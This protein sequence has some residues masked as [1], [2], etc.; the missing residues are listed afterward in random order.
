[1]HSAAGSA[2]QHS[3]RR[4]HGG[5]PELLSVHLAQTLVALDGDALAAPSLEFGDDLLDPGQEILAC[6]D[7]TDGCRLE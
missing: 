6:E 2:D 1:M 4:I 5:L 7:P 3:D